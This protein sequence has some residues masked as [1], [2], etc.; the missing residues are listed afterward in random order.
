MHSARAFSYKILG[1]IVLVALVGGIVIASLVTLWPSGESED[2][3]PIRRDDHLWRLA[4]YE[5]GPF[6]NYPQYL[7]ALL[8]GLIALGWMEPITLPVL[9][10][11]DD[12]HALWQFLADNAQSDYLTFLPDAFWSAN[13]DDAQRAANRADAI[14][15]LAHGGDIDLIIA[16]GT[17]AGLDLATNDHAVPTLVMSTSNPIEAGIIRSATDSGYDHVHAW[18]DPERFVRQ[19]RLFYEIARFER[20]GVIYEDT[21]DGRTYANLDEL[22]EV[23]Q[24][25]HFELVLCAAPDAGVSEEEARQGVQRCLAELAPRVDAMWIGNAH[26]GFNTQAMPGLLAPLFAYKVPSWSVAGPEQ[27]ARGVLLSISR[28]DLSGLGLWTGRVVAQ[29]FHGV[30]PRA[31]DQVYVMSST[32]DINLETARRIGFLLPEGLLQVA[33]ERYEAIEGEPEAG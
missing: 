6:Y 15:R 22:T 2:V 20:L 31:I 30:K 14:D 13:W 26:R 32:I 11:P 18:C 4:Y 17:W 25:Q 23:A 21:P 33:D 9:D 27:V 8:D 24:Q 12:A 7:T 16:M 29:I 19:A 3:S 10:P 1:T 28:R 5:G